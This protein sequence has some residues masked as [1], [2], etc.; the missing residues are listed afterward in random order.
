[1]VMASITTLRYP[2]KSHRKQLRL[3]E[4]SPELAEFFGIMIGDGGIGNPWQAIIT[5]NSVADAK[6]VEHVVGLCEDL[7]DI[8]P[9]VRKRKDKKDK[10]ALVI[11]LTSTTIVDFLVDNGLHRGNKLKQGLHIPE[12]ILGNQAYELACVRGLV[13]TDGCLYIH[14]HSVAQK[15]YKNIGLAFSSY[16]PQLISEV[17]AIFEE[18]GIMPHITSRGTD[19]Y[20]YRADAVARYLEV[21][22]SSN[23]R[24]SSVYAEWKRVRAV[25]GARL[26]SV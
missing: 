9:A 5:L 19:I 7:F 6:Y 20:L 26:E 10:K 14:K 25:E 4:P 18:N 8:S 1:M 11:C 16:S 15:M 22:G 2:K 21:F 13:D 17:A 3:P 24:I 23:P 12:W